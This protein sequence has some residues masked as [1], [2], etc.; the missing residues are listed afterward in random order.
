MKTPYVVSQDACDLL[1]QAGIIAPSEAQELIEIGLTRILQ[2]VFPENEIH[3]ISNEAM[4][5]SL[6][7]MVSRSPRPNIWQNRTYR[8]SHTPAHTIEVTR[9]VLPDGKS[10]PGLTSRHQYLSTQEQIARI[11]PGDYTLID[12]VIFSGVSTMDLVNPLKKKDINIREVIACIVISKGHEIISNSG[13]KVSGVLTYEDV[14]DEVCE[15]DFVIGIPY[16]GRAVVGKPVRR[17]MHYV[18]PW[19]KPKD[20]ASIPP[21]HVVPFSKQCLA[22]SINFWEMV[23]PQIK[24]SEVPQLPVSAPD[25]DTTLVDYLHQTLKQL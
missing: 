14:I 7:E 19:G 12:D 8:G 9:A 23:N 4:T 10:T 15:R 5:A 6:A 24:L 20:W 18:L 25:D 17:S 16:G 22:L 1:R 11:P 21:E 3:F 2:T 13:I